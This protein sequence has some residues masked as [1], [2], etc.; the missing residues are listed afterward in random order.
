MLIL[1]YVIVRAILASLFLHGQD[2]AEVDLAK[3]AKCQS[4]HRKRPCKVR[5]VPGT[6]NVKR[7]RSHPLHYSLSQPRG[8]LPGISGVAWQGAPLV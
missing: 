2:F 3:L 1:V 8:V 6:G 4:K 5:S 7:P